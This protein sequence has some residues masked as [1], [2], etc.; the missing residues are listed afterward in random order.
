MVELPR[1]NWE[2]ERAANAAIAARVGAEVK[3]RA[4][5]RTRRRL[6]AHTVAE[7]SVR[8]ASED[9]N[10]LAIS[11]CG[12]R[13]PGREMLIDRFAWMDVS[14][15]FGTRWVI[16]QDPRGEGLCICA[17]GTDPATR[18]TDYIMEPRADEV[19]VHN[20]QDLTD[21]RPQNLRLVPDWVWMKYMIPNPR[22]PRLPKA[23]VAP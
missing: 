11:I 10:T 1:L 5:A 21:M 20:N 4:E 12:N 9:G 7:P 8:T 14:R 13:G 17:E 19:T 23:P 2:A 6:K 16:E 3:Q 15:R 22:L 18:L